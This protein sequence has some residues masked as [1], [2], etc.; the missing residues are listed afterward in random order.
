MLPAQEQNKD[1]R[2][3]L[4]NLLD[5]TIVI[6]KQSVYN[7]F[8]KLEGHNLDNLLYYTE[9]Q[10]YCPF[11]IMVKL[12]EY[13]MM[14]LINNLQKQLVLNYMEHNQQLYHINMVKDV[15][16]IIFG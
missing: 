16:Q 7:Y 13:V 12:E 15:I 3:A 4:T 10:V 6:G 1:Y 9:I 14:V 2:I 8:V 11:C 5:N